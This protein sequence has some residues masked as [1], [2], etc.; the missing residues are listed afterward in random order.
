MLDHIHTPQ[1]GRG[2]REVLC[3]GRAIRRCVYADTELGVVRY[4][5]SPYRFVKNELIYEEAEGTVL[6]RF[7]N[8]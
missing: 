4:A 7:L 2:A 8:A 3:D 5:A 1:D 6:V